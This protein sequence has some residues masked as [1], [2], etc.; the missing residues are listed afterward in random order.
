MTLA[1]RRP[2]VKGG[3]N[4]G[5]AG[6]VPGHQTIMGNPRRCRCRRLLRR[7]RRRLLLRETQSPIYGLLVG[8]EN[9]MAPCR[10]GSERRV[11]GK[12]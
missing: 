4:H 10:I 8:G 9:G 12:Q 5:P 1:R 2:D 11:N 7:R 6:K 3:T